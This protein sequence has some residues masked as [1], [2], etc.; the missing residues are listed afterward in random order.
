V[1]RALHIKSS[2]ISNSVQTS[3]SAAS[4]VMSEPWTLFD[5]DAGT[6]AAAARPS[7]P[8]S[9]ALS[10]SSDDQSRL[11]ASLHGQLEMTQSVGSSHA[12]RDPCFYITV[13]NRPTVR[14][15]L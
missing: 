12:T 5:A 2:A 4:V 14:I 9:S 13:S 1:D 10:L 11:S 15:G 8:T 6:A 3:D 7:C